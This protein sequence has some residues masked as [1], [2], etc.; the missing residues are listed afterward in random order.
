MGVD[1][2]LVFENGISQVDIPCSGVKSL[3]S[4]MMFLLAAT[5]I[6]HKP[7]NLRWLL[8]AGVFGVLLFAANLARVAALVVVGPVAGWPLLAEMLHLPLGVL[9]FAAACAAA[10]ALLDRWVAHATTPGEPAP[11][12]LLYTSPSPRD[13]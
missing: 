1:T 6:R 3:W 10:V 7:I 2:I 13:S 8:V 4:G 11:A 9:G 5:W 12:C